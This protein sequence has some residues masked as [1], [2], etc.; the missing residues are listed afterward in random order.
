[1]KYAKLVSIFEGKLQVVCMAFRTEKSQYPSLKLSYL[2]CDATVTTIELMPDTEKVIADYLDLYEDSQ[3]IEVLESI[4]A[5]RLIL[6]QLIPEQEKFAAEYYAEDSVGQVVYLTEGGDTQMYFMLED[7]TAGTFGLYG[8]DI[9]GVE[10]LSD[11]QKHYYIEM[12]Q[13]RVSPESAMLSREGGH[14][15]Y[16]N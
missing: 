4:I 9:D 3:L 8:I 2:D 12:A 15:R 13:G 16:L 6:P 14:P 7:E 10:A 11:H 5:P 1:M